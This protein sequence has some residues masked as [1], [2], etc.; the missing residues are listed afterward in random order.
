MNQQKSTSWEPKNLTKNQ[1]LS[2]PLFQAPLFLGGGGWH[3]ETVLS[4]T[5]VDSSKLAT[6]ANGVSNDAAVAPQS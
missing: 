6:S 2:S 3:W 5:R 4:W 1:W